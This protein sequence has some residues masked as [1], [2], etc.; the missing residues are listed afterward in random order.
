MVLNKFFRLLYNQY[1]YE[2]NNG[3]LDQ[4]NWITPACMQGIKQ[5]QER[6][7]QRINPLV[8]GP[9]KIIHYS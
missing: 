8:Y 7:H 1:N 6:K 4:K 3:E 9:V 2:H 5:L